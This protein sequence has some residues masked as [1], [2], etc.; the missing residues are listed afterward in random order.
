[1]AK[2][3]KNHKPKSFTITLSEHDTRVLSHYAKDRNMTRPM[4]L[5]R[6]ARAFLRDYLNRIGEL[7]AQNQLSLFSVDRQTNLLDHITDND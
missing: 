4:A 3:K 6:I 1:M 5:K 7:P 2:Q